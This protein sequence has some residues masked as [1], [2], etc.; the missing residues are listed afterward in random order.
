MSNGRA[1]D[2]LPLE[3]I[4]GNRRLADPEPQGAAVSKPPTNKNGAL[5]SAAPCFFIAL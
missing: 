1:N 2:K 3:V 4:E 5:E